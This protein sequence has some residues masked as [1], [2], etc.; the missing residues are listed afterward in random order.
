MTQRM[1]ILTVKGV[2]QTEATER[3]D[4]RNLRREQNR[5]TVLETLSAMFRE[6]VYQPTVNEVAARAGVSLRSLFRYFDDVDD[7]SHAAIERELHLASPL[8]DIACDPALPLAVR[9]RRTVEA[10]VRLFEAVA[11][12]ARAARAFASKN[13]VVA[14]RVTETRRQLRGHLKTTFAAEI[15]RRPELLPALD[16][17]CSF[18]SYDLMRRDQ[19]LSRARALEVLVVAFTALLGVER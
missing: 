13:P 9:V 5:E 11:P 1:S 17:L 16:V 7:L 14:E 18:E 6:G 10:R 12:A 15:E 8:F 3:V 19:R 4:G 2:P